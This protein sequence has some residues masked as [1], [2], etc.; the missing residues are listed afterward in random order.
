MRLDHISECWQSKTFSCKALS[1]TRKIFSTE[2]KNFLKSKSH[3]RFTV[4]TNQS[5]IF[6]SLFIACRHSLNRHQSV[7]KSRAIEKNGISHLLEP[8][9]S[10]QAFAKPASI[11]WGLNCGVHS[12]PLRGFSACLHRL[13]VC[14]TIVFI[15]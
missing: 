15:A 10:L 12:T 2:A 1:R 8:I 9:Y 7:T 4:T 5:H 3:V 14:S 13:H 11:E 6:W